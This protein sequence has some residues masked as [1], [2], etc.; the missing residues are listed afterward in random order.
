MFQ[1]NL[2]DKKEKRNKDLLYDALI[3][4][5]GAAGL[6]AA[7]YLA[8]D[9]WKTLVL[10]KEAAGG[11]AASTHLI[12]NYPG[13]P[14]G[15]AGS[16][17]MARFKSQAKRFGVDLVEFEEVENITE[18]PE[19]IFEIRTKM[20]ESYKTK[21]VLLAT[22]SVPKRLNIS[23][24]EEYYG[25]GVSYCATCDGPLYKDKNV[26]VIGYGD[27][28]LQ[29]GQVLLQYAN[30][31][32]FIYYKPQSASRAKKVLQNRV[33]AHKKTK[34]L[35][36]HQAKEIKG[37]TQVTSLLLNDIENDQEKEVD[38]SGIFIYVGYHPYTGFVKDL[39][40][41]DENNYIITDDKMRTSHP[42]IFAAGD[43]R[44]G[45]VAQVAVAVGDGA[46]A[47]VSIREYL[48]SKS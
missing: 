48:H 9:G 29:E 28:A 21:T 20:G 35:F 34:G 40:D 1:L 46:N 12:E 32:T 16:D 36:S 2:E 6:T 39:I 26:A 24:E 30:Q 37:D 27:S 14:D 18:Q 44:S 5:A 7:I 33:L 8:R 45:N 22:G 13:F 43:V 17:L 3:I 31:V 19:S 38:F 15:I 4:G 10:E 47:A 25:K 23:G 11:L 41:L 42:G